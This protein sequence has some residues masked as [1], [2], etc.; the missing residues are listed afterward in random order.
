[1][2]KFEPVDKNFDLTK[3]S[4]EE[5]FFVLKDEVV[6]L[7]KTFKGFENTT[8]NDVILDERNSNRRKAY[9]KDG[10]IYPNIVLDINVKAY[11]QPESF[12]LFIDPY[13]V[14]L[15]PHKYNASMVE[16]EDLTNAFVFYMT[17]KFPES[18]YTQKRDEYFKKA[19]IMEKASLD[20]LSL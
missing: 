18:S 12:N 3:V 2:I 20:A 1:M 7:I 15:A 5:L 16:S 11:L 4:D 8:S 6:N 13:S 19:E 17:H 14:K 10:N 9:G